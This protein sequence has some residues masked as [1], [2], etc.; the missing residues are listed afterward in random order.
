MQ[1]NLNGFETTLKELLN[2]S[3]GNIKFQYQNENS[4]GFHVTITSSIEEDQFQVWGAFRKLS[5]FIKM[6][7][8]KHYYK[9]TEYFIG[10]ITDDMEMEHMQFIA[11]NDMV[12][13]SN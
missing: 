10:Y 9:N 8:F 2:I 13:D 11:K 4:K 1:V 6:R 3:N 12:N 5:K 7:D